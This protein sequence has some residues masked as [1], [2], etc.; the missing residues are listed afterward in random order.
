MPS[1]LVLNKW[2]GGCRVKVRLSMEQGKL[3][4]LRN[5]QARALAS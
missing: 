2:G 1:A 5:D 3:S 4:F